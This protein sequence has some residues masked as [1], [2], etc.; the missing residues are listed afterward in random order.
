MNRAGVNRIQLMQKMQFG[1]RFHILIHNFSESNGVWIS[2]SLSLSIE[3]YAKALTNDFEMQFFPGSWCQSRVKT[4]FNINPTCQLQWEILSN[5][6]QT[7]LGKK[8]EGNCLIFASLY[9]LFF[10]GHV[11]L[12]CTTLWTCNIWFCIRWKVRLKLKLVFK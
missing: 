10:F 9:V 1:A 7:W 6:Q 12:I 11:F 8:P 5:K 4:C 2:L 3:R